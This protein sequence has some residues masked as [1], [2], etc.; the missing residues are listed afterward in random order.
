M[1]DEIDDHSGVLAHIRELEPLSVRQFRGLIGEVGRDQL[2]KISLLIGLVE[3]AESVCEQAESGAQKDALRVHIL[4][5][6][7]G[8]IEDRA[9][10][11]DHIV[12]DDRVLAV[13]VCAEELVGNDGILAVYDDGIIS[14]FIEH[15]CVRADDVGKID[16]AVQC[17]FIGGD[18]HDVVLV[19]D[20]VVHGVHQ[21]LHKLVRGCEV[22]EVHEGVDILDP[23]VVGVEGD[24]VLDAQITELLVHD[25]GVKRLAPASLV[26]AALI[27]ERH[28]DIDAPRLAVDGSDHSLEILEMIVRR[29][30]VD[31]TV[32]LIGNG[33]VCDIYKYIDIF[34]SG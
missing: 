27:Q 7:S 12:D 21:R 26:L 23:G 22:A 6:L 20:Q 2:V 25:R 15:T 10:G 5:E 24:E 13:E 18:D 14:S 28:D 30:M 8:G 31:K 11:G 29:H 33:M 34:S 9:A 16:C 3:D 17:A 19:D 1:V 4:L 32:H